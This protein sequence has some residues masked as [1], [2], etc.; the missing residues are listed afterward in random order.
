M[1][2]RYNK[3]HQQK[4]RSQS[5]VKLKRAKQ[6]KELRWERKR[7]LIEALG[8]KCVDCGFSGHMSAL[9][10]DHVNPEDKEFQIAYGLQ[11][12][13]YEKLLHEAS[14]CVL[15]CANCH[16]IKTYS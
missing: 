3:E 16:R 1:R 8:G 6:F 4:Y 9:D 11:S 10:F 2:T 15:R 5:H 7:L 13:S 12:H 14:K